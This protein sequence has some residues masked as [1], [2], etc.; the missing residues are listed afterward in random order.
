VDVLKAMSRPTMRFVRCDGSGGA[1]AALLWTDPRA[2]DRPAALSWINRGYAA[3]VRCCVTAAGPR[4]DRAAIAQIAQ[5]AGFGRAGRANALRP[6]AGKNSKTAGRNEGDQVK[7]G[8]A[9]SQRRR[10]RLAQIPGVGPIG[11]QRRGV[12][13]PD[14]ATRFPFRRHFAAWPR[15]NERPLHAW[16]DQD[17]QDH[18]RRR[19]EGLRQA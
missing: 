10:P 17:R 4:Q 2:A 19:R 18:P 5:E 13:T 9:S 8:L 15:L 14:P 7:D 11:G 1:A 6:R 12:K 3:V 16:Q